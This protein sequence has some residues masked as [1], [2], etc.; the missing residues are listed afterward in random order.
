MRAE[1]AVAVANQDLS[2]PHRRPNLVAVAAAVAN[3]PGALPLTLRWLRE[4]ACHRLLLY[5]VIVA[6]CM[7]AVIAIFFVVVRGLMLMI[8]TCVAIMIYVTRRRRRW[9]QSRNA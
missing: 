4:V 2:E 8:N 3:A 9:R 1:V 5:A 7:V 6:M